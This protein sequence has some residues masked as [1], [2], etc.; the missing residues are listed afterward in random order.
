MEQ[1][2]AGLR[3]AA[4]STRLRILAVLSRTDLTVSELTQVLGQSQPRVSRH[5][6]LL[7]DAGLLTRFQE[8]TWVFY[9]L[10]DQGP[11]ADLAR[12][13]LAELPGDDTYL[14]RDLERLD[15]VRR[16]RAEAAAQFFK[17]NAPR[18]DRIRSLYVPETE[19]ERAMLEAVK[20]RR[21]DDLL[22]IGTGTGRI[23]Q[24]FADRVRRGLGIDLSRE[25]LAVARSNL[26]KRNLRHCHVRQGDIYNL[27]V[28]QGSMDVVT[29]HHV[30]HFLD[31]PAAAIREAA[32]VL[33]PDG[34]LLIVDFAPHQLEFLRNEY[35]H[36]RLGFTDEEVAGWCKATGLEGLRI[37]HLRAKGK[38]SKDKLIVT[39]WAAAQNKEAGAHYQLEVA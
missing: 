5:L 7:C 38:K 39:L 13:V 28:P 23:L 8:G 32:R 9:R 1:L 16:A 37:E 36:R 25:M 21:V 14:A 35:A 6:K 11:G 19:V 2:L 18:W 31:D 33:R 10:A 4:E 30:L 34:R 17:E 3:A 29:I 12:A 24:I 27:A 26:E 20:D 22:D 15:A